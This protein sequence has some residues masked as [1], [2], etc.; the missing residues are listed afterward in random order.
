MNAKKNE[1]LVMEGCESTGVPLFVGKRIGL[2]ARKLRFRESGNTV[3]KYGFTLVK[4]IRDG[5][6]SRISS[7]DIE[8]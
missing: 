5:Q 4:M 3:T 2:T 7:H 6:P 1:A 8:A